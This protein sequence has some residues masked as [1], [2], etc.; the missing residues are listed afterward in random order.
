MFHIKFIAL[1]SLIFVCS[2]GNLDRANQKTRTIV[3]RDEP[4]SIKFCDFPANL[5]IRVKTEFVYSGI[6]EYWSLKGKTRCPNAIP[7]E[8]DYSKVATI[9][10]PRFFQKLD[11]LYD[12]YWKYHLV[13]EAIGVFEVDSI[14][15]Y[16]HL[17]TNKAVFKTERILSSTLSGRARS[18]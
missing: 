7:V 5:G 17:N 10:V 9:A 11:R 12:K 2:H 18:K 6:E 13:V 8:F 1:G 4:R 16:G 14:I 15:G 3:A